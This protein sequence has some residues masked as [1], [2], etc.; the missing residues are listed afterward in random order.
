MVGLNAWLVSNATHTNQLHISIPGWDSSIRVIENLLGE[1]TMWP[2][3]RATV[4]Y[5]ISP[6]NL[7]EDK[8]MRQ[9]K[10]GSELPLSQNTGSQ[11]SYCI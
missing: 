8:I 4:P 1:P 5:L 6:R 11:L 9:N 10:L 2:M 3:L 7:E